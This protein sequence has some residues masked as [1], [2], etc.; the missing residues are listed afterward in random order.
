MVRRMLAKVTKLR[1]KND[2]KKES[3]HAQSEKRKG[4]W[5]WGCRKCV[6]SDSLIEWLSSYDFLRPLLQATPSL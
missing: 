4:G 2:R 3:E 1:M 5:L 6:D